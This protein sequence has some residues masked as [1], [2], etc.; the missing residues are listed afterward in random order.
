MSVGCEFY[1]DN[2]ATMT[3]LNKML[4]HT[5]GDRTAP[6]QEGNGKIA[7]TVVLTIVGGFLVLVILNFI[8]CRF[9][10]RAV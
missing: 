6:S 2:D 7:V 1:T 10:T 9:R 8:F 5:A 4:G 3:Q